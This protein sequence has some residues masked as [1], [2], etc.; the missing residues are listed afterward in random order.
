MSKSGNFDDLMKSASNAST[1]SHLA[2]NGRFGK[3]G[4]GLWIRRNFKVVVVAVLGNCA[5]PLGVAG[6]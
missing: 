6:A 5:A 1:N 2:G 4:G 3:A